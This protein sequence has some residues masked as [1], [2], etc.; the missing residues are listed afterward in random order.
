MK[1]QVNLSTEN[2][3][4]VCIFSSLNELIIFV[5]TDCFFVKMTSYCLNPNLVF[6]YELMLF[7]K[8]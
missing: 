4:C 6:N 3:H 5:S 2:I 8:P 1:I 7:F